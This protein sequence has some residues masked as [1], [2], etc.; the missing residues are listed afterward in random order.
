M[1]EDI[2]SLIAVAT[3][4]GVSVADMA[5]E[6]DRELGMRRHVWKGYGPRSETFAS[7]AHQRRYNV[8]NETRDLLRGLAAS[9]KDGTE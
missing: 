1:I 3:L 6:A 5:L 8:M 7:E 4:R 2:K 9:M